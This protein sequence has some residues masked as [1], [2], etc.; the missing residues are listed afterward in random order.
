MGRLSVESRLL[1]SA[2]RAL[3]A[4]VGVKIAAG[5]AAALLGLLGFVGLFAVSA[6]SAS[7]ATMDCA[8][9]GAHGEV[10]AD[11]FPW[12]PQA[13]AKYRLGPR[14]PSIVAA[15]HYVESDWGR[16]QLPGVA[17]GTENYMGAEGPG[18]FLVSSWASY[19]VDAN[20]DGVKDAYSIPDSVF[21]TARLLRADGAPG[22]WP[23]AIFD[24][25]HAWWYVDKVLAKAASL[26]LATTCT[27]VA[28]SLGETAART[29]A[30]LQRAAVWIESRRLHYCWG[31]GHGPQ[32]GPSSG[33]Y[34]WN[35]GGEQVFG[36]TED[37]LDCSGAVRWL[38]VL[39]GFR[40]PGPLIS[41][42]FG[43]HYPSGPGR[44]VTVF[45]NL[46]HVWIEIAG[47]DWGT[48]TSN[49]A[50]GP[51][52]GPQSGEGFAVSHPPGL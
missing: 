8:G 21:A 44:E 47:R 28:E 27:L 18:Q 41:N 24:Y 1:R 36:A 49:F 12:L 7:Q 19:G 42:E 2:R 45:S 35:S 43:D 38:L 48:A 37:G 23:D 13:A 39:S 26:H 40:D 50:H 10:P 17:P 5:S 3:R 11:Y 52:Y 32:P 4:G 15:I 29:L 14:G 16:S 34:C 51:G 31:G 6:P 9:V 33:S 22:D 30:R 25:N 46:D 20:G